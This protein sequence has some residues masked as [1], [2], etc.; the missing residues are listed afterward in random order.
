V[1]LADYRMP[2]MS[3]IE[4]LEEAMDLF[5]AARRVLLTAYADTD[6]TTHTG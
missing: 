5:P 3:G 1:P 2:R 4:C 6:A